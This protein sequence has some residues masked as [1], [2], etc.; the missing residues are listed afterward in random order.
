MNT[1][2][3]T[4]RTVHCDTGCLLVDPNYGALQTEL[5]FISQHIKPLNKTVQFMSALNELA[6]QHL[7]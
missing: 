5:I 3:N 4:Q 2:D 7:S 1:I 6:V